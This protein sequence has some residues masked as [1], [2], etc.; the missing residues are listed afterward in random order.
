MFANS[1][2]AGAN[3]FI[4]SGW[5]FNER[6]VDA[7]HAVADAMDEA[8]VDGFIVYL[9]AKGHLTPF[10]PASYLWNHPYFRLIY[11]MDKIHL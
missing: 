4:T 9:N 3:K 6:D 5:E 8:P 1:A 2:S 11:T 7:L 10:L